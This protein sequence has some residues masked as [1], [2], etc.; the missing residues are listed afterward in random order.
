VSFASTT[1]GRHRAVTSVPGLPVLIVGPILIG[2][3]VLTGTRGIDSWPFAAYPRSDYIAKSTVTE[4]EVVPFDA[5]GVP[6][7]IAPDALARVKTRMKEARWT[8]V[9]QRVRYLGRES[10]DQ[11][12]RAMLSVLA[13]E[14]GRL[15]SA[16]GIDLFSTVREVDPAARRNPLSRAWVAHIMVDSSVPHEDVRA[17]RN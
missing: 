8:R 12:V 16:V 13:G 9:V 11:W 4:L 17:A 6:I 14:D 15:K 10:R 5:A 2:A 1:A 3:A 7:V